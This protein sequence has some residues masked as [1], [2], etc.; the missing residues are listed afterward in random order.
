MRRNSWGGLL[1]LAVSV[2]AL[3]GGAAAAGKEQPLYAERQDLSYYLDAQ[4]KRQPIRTSA[5]W[6]RRREHL[7]LGMQQVMGPLPGAE[8]RAPLA[9]KVE[10]EVK[11]GDLIRRKITYNTSP[12]QRVAAYLFL[13]P[14]PAGKKAPAM[15]CLHPTGELGKRIV[16][17]LGGKAHRQYALELAQRGYVTLAPDYPTFGD[18]QRDLDP[19][20]GWQSGSM[21]AIWDNIRSVDLLQSMSEV[22]GGKIGAIGHSLGGHNAMFTGVFE[23]RIKAVVSSCG[24]TRFHKYYE[25]NLTG[26]TSSRYMPRIATV[27]EKSPDRMPFDFPEIVAALAPRAFFT[28]SPLRDSN[29]EVSGV[30]DCIASARP[31]FALHGKP[32][33]L[34]AIYPESEHDFP[35]EARAQA[36]AFLDRRLK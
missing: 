36:Y 3:A 31:V 10:E 35:D 33:N 1:L 4:G 19:N 15:L 32:E 26:W 7:L 28:S 16:A 12:K 2:G 20:D 25:G 14:L 22:D 9:V 13:P 11:V 23:P 34:Q 5:D 18:Y 30:R 29:F 21:R 17:A 6:Q 8:L 24:F 27:Y